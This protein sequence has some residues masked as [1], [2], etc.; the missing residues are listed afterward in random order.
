M[1]K[2]KPYSA[3]ILALGGFMLVAM[4]AYFVFIRPTLLPEDYRYIGTTPLFIQEKIPQL[5]IWLQKVFWVLGAYV[6]TSGLLTIFIAR[7]S[8]RTRVSGVYGIVAISGTSSIGFMTIV[9]FMIES[10][11]RWVLLSFTVS[12]IVA[13][14]LYL[15]HK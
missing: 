5:S 2:L 4:G 6:F 15:L 14:I 13:L 9:N 3:S 8:F 11:F 12:W 7:T 10:D 1:F